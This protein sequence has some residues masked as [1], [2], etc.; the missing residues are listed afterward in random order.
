MST[1]A[2]LDRLLSI[3]CYQSMKQMAA[4]VT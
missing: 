3:E 1:T 4:I 2:L